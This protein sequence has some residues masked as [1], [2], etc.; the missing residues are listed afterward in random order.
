MRINRWL[1]LG[2][3]GAVLDLCLN[4]QP[5]FTLGFGEFCGRQQS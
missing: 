5:I 4:S 3:F 2:E 1:I